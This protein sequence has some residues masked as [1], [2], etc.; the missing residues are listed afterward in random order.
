MVYE[1]LCSSEERKNTG[2]GVDGSLE[3]SPATV[4]CNIVSLKIFPFPLL[5]VEQSCPQCCGKH[6]QASRDGTYVDLVIVHFG[7][8]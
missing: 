6:L 8:L 5:N 7:L 3:R 1:V 4:H 2:L